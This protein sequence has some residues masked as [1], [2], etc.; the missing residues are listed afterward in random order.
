MTGFFIRLYHFFRDHQAVY[1][2]TM[3]ALFVVL[4]FF[5]SRIHLEEDID[6]LMPSWRP[7]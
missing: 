3:V 5:A 4:G 2:L 6:K 1:W 7:S